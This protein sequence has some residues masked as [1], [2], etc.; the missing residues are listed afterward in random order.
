MKIHY[1]VVL[2]LSSV[3]L[4]GCTSKQKNYNVAKAEVHKGPKEK[5]NKTNSSSKIISPNNNSKQT[6]SFT[7]NEK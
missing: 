4:L 6:Q 3:L 2:V 1:F 5:S 7:V